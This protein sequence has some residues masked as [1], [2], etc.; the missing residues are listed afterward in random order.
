MSAEERIRRAQRAAARAG[1]VA[2]NSDTPAEQPGGTSLARARWA[3]LG[4]V[5]L[6]LLVHVVPYGHV[7]G[8]PLLWLSTMVHELGHGLTAWLVGASFET[9]EMFPN[10]SGVALWRG[11]VGP[12]GR[13]MISAGGLLGPAIGAAFCFVAMRTPRGTRYVLQ[14]LGLALLVMLPLMGNLF[15]VAFVVG[16]AVLLGAIGRYADDA[17][18]RITLG[19][20][21]V[22][23]A[24]S[25]FSRGD[26]LF[27]DVANTGAGT[28]PSDVAQIAN[29]LLLPYWFWGGL[30]GL[31]SLAILV[32]GLW[33]SVGPRRETA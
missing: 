31:L 22:Q 9:F 7:V 21:G 20:F 23:L 19:F 25:V 11:T 28:M 18:A 13:A 16:L 5:V 32:G 10:G 24:L 26:Y 6:T 33:L 2:S 1:D 8:R 12:V 15:T 3:L 27:T 17:I 4:S 30:I 29:A 14:G